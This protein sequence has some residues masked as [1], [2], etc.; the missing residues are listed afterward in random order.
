MIH[1]RQLSVQPLLTLSTDR[2]TS[3]ISTLKPNLTL[4]SCKS[5]IIAFTLMNLTP[6]Q[7]FKH[8]GP[9]WAILLISFLSLTAG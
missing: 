7:L 5:T 3:P 9:S 8:G 6:M 1:D 4:S 2:S